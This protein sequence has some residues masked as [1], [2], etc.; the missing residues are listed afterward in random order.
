MCGTDECLSSGASM[1][2]LVLPVINLATGME[3]VGG[4]W[5]NES[6]YW[7]P[8]AI[9]ATHN[10]ITVI[11]RIFSK[12]VCRDAKRTSTPL[13]GMPRSLNPERRTF[14]LSCCDEKPRRFAW[15]F[16]FLRARA[17]SLTYFWASAEFSISISTL[18]LSISAVPV[19][20]KTG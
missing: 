7:S 1:L 16:S 20:T 4:V 14:E 3:D 8:H 13:Q 11:W 10:V 19:S 6:R 12:L 17:V 15:V 9:M 2:A 5:Y 18:V